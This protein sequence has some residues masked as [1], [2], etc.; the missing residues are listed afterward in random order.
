MML[1]KCQ[2]CGEKI[3]RDTAYKI[4]AKNGN[5]YY[6]SLNEYNENE[7]KKQREAA[8]KERVY[9][10]I[11]GIMGEQ[12]IIST[13]LYK[14][15][16]VWLKVADNAKIAKYLEENESYLT[17]AIA[18]LSSSEYAKIRYISTIIRDKIKG[19]RPKS[20]TICSPNI[21]KENSFELFEPTL[22]HKPKV[23]EQILYDVEDDLI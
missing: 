19:F 22:E 4:A 20:V 13:A 21:S 12:E 5:K 7:Q 8:D 3:D 23:E 18:R 2:I 10:L 11:C 16:Q 6:C 15:W 17:S 1:V 14:E 9:R